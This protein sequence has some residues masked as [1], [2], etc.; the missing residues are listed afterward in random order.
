MGVLLASELHRYNEADQA[1]DE[2]LK[3]IHKMVRYGE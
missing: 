1:F 3:Q 2:A